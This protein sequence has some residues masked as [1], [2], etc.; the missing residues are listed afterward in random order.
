[1]RILIYGR[2]GQVATELARLAPGAILLD[3]GAAD[4]S[5]PDA[6]AAALTGTADRT[7]VDAVVNAAAWTAVD[8]AE[9]HRETAF[10]VNG[11]APGAIACAA[12]A[13]GLPFVHISTD[14]VFDGSRNGGRPWRPDDPVAP[15]GAY[16]A[17]KAA[18]EAGVRAA[19]GVHAILRTS[20]VFSA[21]GQNFVK[22]ML[23]LGA[24]RERLRVVAD[25]TGGPT[26]AAD[27][28]RACLAV[29]AALG[30]DPGLSGTYHY[31]GAPDTSWAGFARAILAGAGLATAVEEIPTSDWPTPAPRPLNS[32]LDCAATET[33]F[34][35]ARPDWR[36]GLAAVLADLGRTR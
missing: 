21:H 6:A 2:T 24:E 12:A 9:D 31:A 27:I 11:A 28:A 4:L 8:A 1:M 19:G 33:A 3:R 14:Y 32:R 35:L 26:P 29:A 22:T 30:A 13:R 25:Q 36:T 17:S 20:W 34:G 18:G 15:L 23:R 5:R 16:G 7:P 10:A